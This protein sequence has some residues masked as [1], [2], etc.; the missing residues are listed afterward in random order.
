MTLNEVKQQLRAGKP[1][2]G[3]LLNFGDPLVAETMAA[4]GLDR[5]LVDTEHGP[6]HL[7]T[8]AM[9]FARITRYPCASLVRVHAL[10]DEN[11]KRVLAVKTDR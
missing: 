9:L 6:I 5:L 3:S 1:A 4:V 8:T 2:L 7:A 11:V 10:S